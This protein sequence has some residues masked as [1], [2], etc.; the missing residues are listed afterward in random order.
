[1]SKDLRKNNDDNP[2]TLRE[3]AIRTLEVMRKLEAKNKK[4]MKTIV[5]KDGTVVSSTS[6]E[7]LKGYKELDKKTLKI[8][9]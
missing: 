3:T 2:K 8:G 5:L 9:Y 6:K 7:R 4:K 1:M